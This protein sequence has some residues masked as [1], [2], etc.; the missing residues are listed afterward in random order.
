MIL[1]DCY[2]FYDRIN[3]ILYNNDIQSFKWDIYKLDI[4]ICYDTIPIII[5]M[6]T[7]MWWRL[8]KRKLLFLWIIGG[9][10]CHTLGDRSNRLILALMIR[11]S[12]DVREN[13]NICFFIY[14]VEVYLLLLS[15]Y[16]L[17]FVFVY[18][19]FFCICLCFYFCIL[20]NAVDMVPSRTYFVCSHT[21]HENMNPHLSLILQLS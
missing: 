7:V 17:W 5:M 9:D 8:I 18:R 3:A 19:V 15:T 14:C 2:T 4:Y 13:R 6:I 21:I 12:R 1:Y 16:F 10:L 11:E 20:I